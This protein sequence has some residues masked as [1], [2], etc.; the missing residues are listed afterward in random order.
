MV[1]RVI[2]IR[3]SRVIRIRVMSVV[4]LIRV[5]KVIMTITWAWLE[6]FINK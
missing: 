2:R 4:R 5:V 6:L 3:S 1:S